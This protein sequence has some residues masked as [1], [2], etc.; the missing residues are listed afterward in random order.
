MKRQK[1]AGSLRTF[2]FVFGF[3]RPFLLPFLIGLLL[4][5]SQQVT[6]T[7]LNSTLMGGVT[8][9]MLNQDYAGLLTTGLAVLGILVVMAS[10]LYLGVVLYANGGLKTTRRLQTKIFRTFVNADVEGRVHSGERLSALNTDV[11]VASEL[12]DSA[13]ANLLMWL[14]PIVV[15]PIAVFAI[16]WRVGLFTVFAGLF[17]MAGQYLFSKPLAKI[18]KG[19]LEGVA[20]ATKTIGDIF[21]GG[22]VARVFSLQDNLL[23]MFGRSNDRL[24]GLAVREAKVSG[25]QKLFAGVSQLL[26]TG[27]VFAVGSILISRG[28]MS[29]VA[30]M[31]MVPMCASIAEALASVGG[32]W[33]GMQAPLEAGKRLYALLEGDNHLE[34]LPEK[35]APLA[36]EGYRIE[37]KNL[38]FS[39]KD[40]EKPVLSGVDLTI[41]ENQLAAFIGG[42]GG[43]KSTLLKVIAGLYDRDSINVTVGG[44]PF[45][46]DNIEG[47]RGC[48]AYVDQSCALFNLTIAENIALGKE[49]ATPEEVRAAAAEADADGFICALPQGYDT[50]VGEVGGMLS[51]GQRQ[52]IAIARAL[53]RRSPILV[54]DEATSALDKQS[55]QEV[56][57]TIDRLR[58]KHTVLMAT[59]NIASIRPDITFRV[60]NGSVA[61]ECM[62]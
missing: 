61:V 18:A 8:S 1:P 34:P 24:L 41:E 42:S 62:L 33:A 53:M 52:R 35:K 44:K 11:T 4:Y 58:A 23:Q 5:T 29:L 45:S 15:L 54:F 28:D 25:A 32:A 48:F 21:S 6:F 17:A 50:P 51:G 43:G 10:L 37:A 2:G 26:T 13:L 19:T 30:L 27:G 12:Y 60:E 3:A 59:H 36:A 7:L 9:A 49:G 46:A 40:A 20:D 47:W 31:A 14:F 38:T 16:E 55:E 22:V 57:A 56:V 39:F